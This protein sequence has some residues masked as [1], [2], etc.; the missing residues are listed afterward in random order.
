MWN[1]VERSL[2]AKIGLVSL[3]CVLA[4]A[5]ICISVTLKRTNAELAHDAA[6]ETA[7]R[8][9]LSVQQGFNGAIDQVTRVQDTLRA[10]HDAG[11]QNRETA[12]IILKQ[13]LG[14]DTDQ[15]G[16]WYAWEPNAYDEHDRDFRNADGADEQGRFLTYWHQNGMEITLDHVRPFLLESAVYRTPMK[17]GQAFLGEPNLLMPVAGMP[18]LVASFGEPLNFDGARLGVIGLDMRLDT[19]NAAIASAN[20]PAGARVLVV[21]TGGTVAAASDASLSGKMLRDASAELDQSYPKAH[22]LAS[23]E[24]GLQALPNGHIRLW[25]ELKIG[26]VDDSWFT[27][28]DLPLSA[29]QRDSWLV[30][31]KLFSIPVILLFLLGIGMTVAIQILILRPIKR[32][33]DV[34]EIIDH[35][36]SEAVIPDLKRTDEIGDIARSIASLRD[37]RVRINKLQKANV[38]SEIDHAKRRAREL[39]QL[40]ES[41][42]ASIAS[43]ATSVGENAHDLRQSA[44]ISA[45]N[46]I[47]DDVKINRL[48]ETAGFARSQIGE[49]AAV[50]QKMMHANELLNS[51]FLNTA[52]SVKDAAMHSVR[53]HEAVRDLLD[54]VE[55]VNFVSKA[56]GGVAQQINLIALNASIEAARA[57]DAGRGFAVV[58]SEVK[59]LALETARAT[60]EIGDRLK[61][62]QSA[63]KSALAQSENITTT[64]ANLNNLSASVL[65][66][67][68]AQN[69]AKIEIE[70]YLKAAINNSEGVDDDLAKV[71]RSVH[72]A[73]RSARTVLQKSS[74]LL[75]ESNKLRTDVSLLISDIRRVSLE[76]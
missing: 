1:G 40:A 20:L 49:V 4:I 53:S 18:V 34:V 61:D 15:Y 16:A 32:I 17:S 25:H 19:I 28:V 38:E 70:A 52:E 39:D 29:F 30:A 45:E 74:S 42:S 67:V 54:N 76:A 6:I 13:A 31:A 12:N 73:G 24:N 7:D 69:E 21:S 64:I 3:G 5:A 55:R 2:S 46:S 65:E 44:E 9:S 72:C 48:V 68:M 11:N 14:R 35:G 22:L 51:R 27:I 33:T 26:E 43:V 41:L 47:E 10:L 71:Q 37:G 59:L 75:S 60:E 8:V 58:A 63:S 23:T 36:S 56:I 62:V 66:S 50:T 57:G